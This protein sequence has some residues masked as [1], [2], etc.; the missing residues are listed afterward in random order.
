MR[1]AILFC[2]S[3][4][5]TLLV[6]LFWTGCATSSTIQSREQERAAAYAAFSPETRRLVN[7]SRISVGMTTN[8]VYIAWGPPDEAIEGTDQHGAVTIWE[9]FA[10]VWEENEYSA[11]VPDPN[12]AYDFQSQTYVCA[13]VVFRDGLVRRWDM[14]HS[15]DDDLRQQENCLDF[16]Q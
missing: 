11:D 9:Y 1:S 12:L 4:S 3:V 14:L 5:L 13:M 2:K 15:P 8:A 6:M 16:K 10:V 7:Q